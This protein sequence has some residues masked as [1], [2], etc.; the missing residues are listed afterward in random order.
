MRKAFVLVLCLALVPA[1]LGVASG[2]KEGP[3]AGA[4]AGIVNGPDVLPIVKPGNKVTLTMFT[5]FSTRVDNFEENVFTKWVEEKTGLSLDFVAGPA[6][7]AKTKLNLLLNS[8]GYPDII[9]KQLSQAEMSMY[10]TQGI[11]IPL[12]DLIK[13]YAGTQTLQLFKQYPRAWDVITGVDGKVYSMPDVNDCYHCRCGA[14]MWARMD[15]MENLGLKLP[16]TTDDFTAMLKAFKERDPN[17]NGKADEVALGGS[18][19]S[20]TRPEKWLLG[21]FLPY[22]ANDSSAQLIIDGKY[23]VG[24]DKPAYREGLRYMRKLHADGLMLKEV[25]SINDAS[26]RQIGE[27]PGVPILGTFP[28]WGPENGTQKGA[29]RWYDYNALPALRGPAGVR[30]AASTGPYNGIMNG[31]FITD[32]CKYPEAAVRLADFFYGFESGMRWYLGEPDKQWEY[33]VKGLPALDGGEAV[34]KELVTYGAQPMNCSWDQVGISFRSQ[35]FRLSNLGTEA[36]EVR[37]H[38]FARDSASNKRMKELPTYN[39][40]MKYFVIEQFA[41]PYRYADDM[42]VPP[43]ILESKKA[44]EMVDLKTG[45]DTYTQEMIA[46]FVTGDVDLDKGWDTYIGELNK[47]GLQRFLQLNQEAYD[48]KYKAKK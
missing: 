17:K 26:L 11:L 13:K 18:N 30:T 12:D 25:Y 24:Y 44:A 7:D 41:Y 27:N 15:W 20:W 8:G 23:S 22:N 16:E 40:V 10:G 28:G 35:R 9:I 31:Y 45:L 1:F 14:R 42:V 39:E 21:A 48:T 5:T 33:T 47:L 3:A 2:Q 38:L 34:Y 36:P 32:K 6:A 29:D 43:L 4:S 37:K 46:R 19:Q